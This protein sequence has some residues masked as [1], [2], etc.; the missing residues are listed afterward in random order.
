LKIVGIKLSNYQK[1][2]IIAVFICATIMTML[3]AGFVSAIIPQ[4]DFAHSTFVSTGY[5]AGPIKGASATVNPGA[6]W[7]NPA[8]WDLHEIS[9]TAFLETTVTSSI[10]NKAYNPSYAICVGRYLD[11][12][13][14]P[15]HYNSNGKLVVCSMRTH[16]W[17][18]DAGTYKL[19]ATV[20]ENESHN[21][22]VECMGPDPAPG[23]GYRSI[24]TVF[25]DGKAMESCSL[26]ASTASIRYEF[27]KRDSTNKVVSTTTLTN[28]MILKKEVVSKP[29]NKPVNKPVRVPA[30]KNIALNSSASSNS[31]ASYG[32][33]FKWVKLSEIPSYIGRINN[34]FN[35]YDV[36]WDGLKSANTV[37][38]TLPVCD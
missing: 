23:K 25:L 35:S 4:K 9:V 11:K 16:A 14:K 10:D 29:I 8:S 3:Q 20:K 6:I 19:L 32:G 36:N 21:L 1:I 33:G 34:E 2:R 24:W 12:S 18:Q 37:K 30:K 31:S 15:G 7:A 38:G 26:P 27:N 17:S 5:N 28:C 22:R 13:T